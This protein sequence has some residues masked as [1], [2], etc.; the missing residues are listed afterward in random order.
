MHTSFT[1]LMYFYFRL[2]VQLLILSAK[3]LRFEFVIF[4]DVKMVV[5]IIGFVVDNDIIEIY[6]RAIYVYFCTS[7]FFEGY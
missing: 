4:P 2:S 3:F 1:V 6:T 7:H 5:V